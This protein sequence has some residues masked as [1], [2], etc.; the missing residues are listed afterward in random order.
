MA[1]RVTQDGLAYHDD[2]LGI[3]VATRAPRNLYPLGT[4]RQILAIIVWKITGRDPADP[5]PRPSRG[6]NPRP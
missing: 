1:K 6:S 2:E 3:E 5:F 4:F